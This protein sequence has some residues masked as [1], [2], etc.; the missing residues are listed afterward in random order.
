MPDTPTAPTSFHSIDSVDALVQQLVGPAGPK[1]D[2]GSAG[3]QGAAGP[4]GVQGP[5]GPSGP[6]GPQGSIGPAGA[7]GDPATPASTIE[8]WT[9]TEN[10]KAVTPLVAFGANAIQALTFGSVV[11]IDGN[12]GVNFSLD[13]TGNTLLANP[14]NMKSGQSGLIILRQD[15]TGSR[16]ISYSTKWKFSGGQAASG[17]L[18]T[19]GNAVDVMSYYVTPTGDILATLLKGF[20]V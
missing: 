2:A 9:G 5:A 17:V 1:G 16:I 19:T 6:Q 8:V 18:S 13:L 12:T 10:T 15:A 7:T 4:Q 14:A 3:P 11:T 20:T